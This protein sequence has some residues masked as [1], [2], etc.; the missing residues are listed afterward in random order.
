[1][2][3]IPGALAARQQGRLALL[4]RALTDRALVAPLL[5]TA[6]DDYQSIAPDEENPQL[7]P[8]PPTYAMHF[9][10][11]AGHHHLLGLANEDGSVHVQDTSRVLPKLPLVGRRCHDNAIFAFCWAGRDAGR[12]ATASGDQT[13][14]V[15]DLQAAEGGGRR[16]RGHTRSVKAVQWR[17]GSDHELA[18]AGRDNTV[19]VWDLRVPGDSVPE[20]AIR[21][22][23]SSAAGGG[24]RRRMGSGM[25]KG[26]ASSV[27]GLCWTDANTLA[28]VG[29]TDGRVKLWDLRKHYSLYR[30]D[31][32][33][34]AELPHPGTSATQGFNTLTADPAATHVFVSCLDSSIYRYDVRNEL[35]QPTATYTG[36]EIKNFFITHSVSPCGRYL[37]SGSSDQWTY[38]WETGSAGGPVA[39]LG[40]QEAE[41]TCVSWSR[42]DS[43]LLAAASDDMRHR[44]WRDSRALPEEGEVRGRAEM[45]GKVDA[46]A[47]FVSPPRGG[48]T[49][50]CRTPAAGRGIRRQGTPSIAAFL[51]PSHR[52]ATS[53]LPTSPLHTPTNDVKRGLKR[54]T[55]DFNDENLEPQ[56]K[57]GRRDLS[58]TIGSLLASPSSR[59]TFSP[60]SY[61]SPTKRQ[62]PPRNL[63]S[64]LKGPPLTPARA[65]LSTALAAASSPTANLPNLVADGRSPSLRCGRPARPP[66]AKTKDWLTEMAAKRRQEE[67]K[68]GVKKTVKKV[69]RKV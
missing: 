3:G 37:A 24:A 48:A 34:R 41:V 49:P 8:E 45:L 39:R 61:Q 23:H 40:P 31:P 2:A 12:L 13:V 53:P 27:T 11:V 4:P 51:T 68:R 18:T 29:D 16:L 60:T 9:C 54:R 52:A 62:S 57:T 55:V 14:A 26:S 44:L 33:P 46:P 64:P 35:A 6:D 42:G 17:L 43:F 32:L 21:S 36:A 22:A 1:M 63:G 30:G 28:T 19:M 20:N 58:M 50:R 5:C 15:W 66:A 10:P 25:E 56:A 7:N 65:N 38:V 47:V 67:A 69:V 59:C